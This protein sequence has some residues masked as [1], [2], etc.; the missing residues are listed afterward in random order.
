MTSV[1]LIRMLIYIVNDHPLTVHN[2]HLLGYSGFT[3]SGIHQNKLMELCSHCKRL[4]D[5][6]YDEFLKFLSEK[7]NPAG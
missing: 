1:D 4:V 3:V 2:I 7:E 5:N 6:K